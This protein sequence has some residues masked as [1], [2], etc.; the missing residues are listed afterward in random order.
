MK[1][2]KKK[3]L[4]HV[5]GVQVIDEASKIVQLNKNINDLERVVQGAYY[6]DHSE[7]PDFIAAGGD[8]NEALKIKR[9][10]VETNLILYRI[11]YQL[12]NKQNLSE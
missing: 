5:D 3:L 11:L 8:Y 6:Y 2:L 10:K 1:G 7:D 4:S 12:T 9:N